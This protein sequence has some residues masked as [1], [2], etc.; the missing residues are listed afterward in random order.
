MLESVTPSE[1]TVG[2]RVANI[3]TTTEYELFQAVDRLV[4]AAD[5][6]DDEFVVAESMEERRD[7]ILEVA[8]AVAA[9]E[10]DEWWWE[11]HASRFVDN[12]ER[13]R[14]FSGLEKDAWRDAIESLAESKRE[15]AED[16][17]PDATDAQLA[18]ERVQ[19][20]FGVDLATFAS[21]IVEWTAHEHVDGI[22]RQNLRASTQTIHQV[23]AALEADDVVDEQ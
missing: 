2:Q 5:V 22:I 1:T 12:P 9:Q 10:F 7:T 8:D 13:A 14:A 21:E 15:A 11:N 19:E 16:G 20:V 3:L 4:D 23:A 17:R 18:D 6:V